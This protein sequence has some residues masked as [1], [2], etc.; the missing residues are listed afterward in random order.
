MASNANTNSF[1]DTVGKIEF[2]NEASNGRFDYWFDVY[3]HLKDNPFVGCGLGNWK[4][5]SI[6]Y[7]KRHINGY[8]VPYHAHNDF[9][10]FFSELGILGG[11]LYLSIFIF[12]FINL[13]FLLI[14]SKN[15][16]VLINIFYPRLFIICLFSRCFIKFS[17]C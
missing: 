12:L 13:L 7:G 11:L 16:R 1:T 17:S 5:A 10:Q 4:I 15:H 9:L 8:T 6:E 14:K 3:N 2:N